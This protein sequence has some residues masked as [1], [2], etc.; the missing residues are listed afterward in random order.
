MAER[1]LIDAI[2]AE[3]VVLRGTERFNEVTSLVG[4]ARIVLLGE[5][6]HGTHEFYRARTEITKRLL[7]EK[8][9]G[10]VAVECDWPDALRVNRFIQGR[11]N[12]NGVPDA[13]AKSALG[14]YQRFPRWMWRNSDVVDLVQWLRE[15]NDGIPQL[16]NKVGFFGLDLYS[17]RTSMDAVIRYL[18]RVD[19]EAAAQARTRYACFDH[20]AEDPQQYGYATTFGIKKDCAEEAMRQLRGL[21]D[22]LDEYMRKDGVAAYDDAFYAQQNARVVQSAEEYYRA[23]FEGRDVSWNLR[24]THMSDTLDALRQ[25]IGERRGGPGKVVVWAHNSHIG[26]ARATEMGEHGQLNLGQLVRERHGMDDTFLLG[27]TTHSGTVTAASEWESPAEL[28]NVR[29]SRSDSIEYLLHNTGLE[30]FLLPIRGRKTLLE[31]LHGHRL[32]RAIGVVY[33]PQSERTSH[34]FYSDIAS[35][36]DAVIH[37][38]H[39]EAVKPLDPSGDMAHVEL[40]ETYPSGM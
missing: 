36:F 34:Y 20:L 5:A 18:S 38:D 14:N 3:A 25:H 39:T 24:D 29:P 26:D 15:F 22:N 37:F 12:D 8:G 7:Q 32:E 6:T 4:D 1:S 23:M 19:P 28:K 35:Q 16:E 40:P 31:K 30:D 2:R 9:F 21:S 13:D 27:F 33:L 17:L 10:A 11:N